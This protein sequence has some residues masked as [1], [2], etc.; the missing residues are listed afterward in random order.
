MK[1][2]EGISYLLNDFEKLE[3]DT[4]FVELAMPALSC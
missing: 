4:V 2:D 3:R 1:K